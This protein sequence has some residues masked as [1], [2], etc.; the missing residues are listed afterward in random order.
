MNNQAIEYHP[1]LTDQ[2][3]EAQSVTLFTQR[4]KVSKWQSEE[5]ET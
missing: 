2:K 4:H 1:C 3:T 5:S